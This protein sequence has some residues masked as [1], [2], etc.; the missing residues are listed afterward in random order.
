MCCYLIHLFHTSMKK[1][2]EKSQWKEYST[3]WCCLEWKKNKSQTKIVSYPTHMLPIWILIRAKSKMFSI[4]VIIEH[5]SLM[6][7]VLSTCASLHFKLCIIYSYLQK[8]YTI[9]VWGAKPKCYRIHFLLVYVTFVSKRCVVSTFILYFYWHCV[10]SE[11][12]PLVNITVVS[13]VENPFSYLTQ[14]F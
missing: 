4:L 14:T 6:S 8:S 10:S 5:F 1:S 12:K 2:L 3:P 9:I 11:I 7:G 13:I